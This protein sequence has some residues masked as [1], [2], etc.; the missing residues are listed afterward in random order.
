MRLTEP[1]F[2]S[3]K[4]P[5]QNLL[6]QDINEVVLDKGN[7]DQRNTF[8]KTTYFFDRHDLVVRNTSHKNVFEKSSTDRKLPTEALITEIQT[9][10]LE[11][12]TFE[13]QEK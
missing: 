6:I 13:Y 2:Q 9:V 1:I 11:E 12:K 5:L 10:A 7:V 4:N 3:S 8:T